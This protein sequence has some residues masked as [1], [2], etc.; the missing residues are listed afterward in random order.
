MTRKNG[1]RQ[2]NQTSRGS[3][4]GKT[5]QVST[6][7]ILVINISS[8]NTP[9]TNCCKFFVSEN[10]FYAYNDTVMKMV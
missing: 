8:N 2:A 7:Y 5:G 1:K 3:N 6:F 10:I 9:T 4:Y